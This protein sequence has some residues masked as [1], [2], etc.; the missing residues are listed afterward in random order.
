MY[1]PP[2]GKEDRSSRPKTSPRRTP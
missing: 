1:Q 2:A